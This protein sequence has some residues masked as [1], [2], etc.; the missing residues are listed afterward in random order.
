VKSDDATGSLIR[1]RDVARIELGTQLYNAKGRF[2]G[3]DAAVLAIY[4][5]P[6]SN[7]LQ[8]ADSIRKTM[9]DLKARF[10]DDIEHIIS[11][12]TTKAVTEGIEEI[13]STLR[14]AIILVLIVVFIFLGSLRATLVPIIAVP[15]SL[16]GTFAVMLVLGFSADFNERSGLDTSC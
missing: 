9:N 16:I 6:G 13:L 4:Q 8:G 11:L 1:L 2:D 12:D 3:E 5:V 10:P 14:D 15:V 7:A